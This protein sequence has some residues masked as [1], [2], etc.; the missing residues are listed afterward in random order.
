MNMPTNSATHLVRDIGERSI[1]GRLAATR[2]RLDR[3]WSNRASGFLQ[4]RDQA[5][6]GISAR[7]VA[8]LSLA[9]FAF[10]AT[11]PIRRH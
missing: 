4:P 5:I 6:A 2:S 9:A 11:P 3:T 8:V 7:A 1:T 10:A